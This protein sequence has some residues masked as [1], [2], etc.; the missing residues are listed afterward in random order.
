MK[1]LTFG[2]SRFFW[3]PFE[4]TLE[5]AVA[6]PEEDGLEDAVVVFVHAEA[7]DF[8]EDRADSVFKKALK[9]TKWLANKRELRRLCL[10]SFAHLADTRADANWTR[11][12]LDELAERL[13]GNGYEVA[14]T[15]FGESC[16]VCHG[17]DADFSVDRVH[18]RNE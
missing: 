11:D 10:H 16:G 15:P 6:A 4:R 17:E 13:R 8:A 3:Q 18:A 9:H 5:D 12:F 14:A 1:L 2:A 7:A